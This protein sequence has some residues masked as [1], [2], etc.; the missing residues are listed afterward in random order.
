MQ[1]TQTWFES[2]EPVRRSRRELWFGLIRIVIVV[3]LVGSAARMIAIAYWPQWSGPRPALQELACPPLAAINP[4]PVVSPQPFGTT[5]AFGT[6]DKPGT[7]L[8]SE[9]DWRPAPVAK[10]EVHRSTAK[11]QPTFAVSPKVDSPP[12]AASVEFAKR[13]GQGMSPQRPKPSA[14]A[15]MLAQT[16]IYAS[17]F[18]DMHGQ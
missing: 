5:E 16:R 18:D 2:I 3:A 6:R 8:F 1:A 12:R 9:S 17:P 10:R 11:K 4:E 15:P 13:G 7:L 14:T